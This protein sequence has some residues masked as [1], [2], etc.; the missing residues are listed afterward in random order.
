M[1]EEH[2]KILSQKNEKVQAEPARWARRAG[3]TS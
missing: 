2:T 3:W 1:V